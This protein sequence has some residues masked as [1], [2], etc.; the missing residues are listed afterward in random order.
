VNTR[1]AATQ[2]PLRRA[3]IGTQLY[4]CLQI[5]MSMIVDEDHA[6]AEDNI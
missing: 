3:M 5:A 6:H 1:T 2:A 4:G